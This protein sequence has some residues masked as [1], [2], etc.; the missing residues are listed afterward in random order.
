[1]LWKIWMIICLSILG[2]TTREMGYDLVNYTWI[3]ETEFWIVEKDELRELDYE[4]MVLYEKWSIPVNEA[5][6]STS[7]I[8]L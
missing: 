7:H 5:Q 8:N 6:S 3:D 2:F 1:M 4:E